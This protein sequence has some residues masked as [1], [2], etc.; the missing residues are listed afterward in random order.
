MTVCDCMFVEISCGRSIMHTY[1][2]YTDCDSK[3]CLLLRYFY[4]LLVY[5]MLHKRPY[6]CIFSDIQDLIIGTIH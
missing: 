1:S 4:Q 5:S 3:S 2:S 6:K